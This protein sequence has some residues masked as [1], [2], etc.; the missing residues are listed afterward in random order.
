MLSMKREIAYEL[1]APARRHYN[2][3]RVTVH[4]FK[5][6]WQADLVEMIPFAKMNNKHRYLLTVIDCFSKYAFAVPLKSKNGV[7]VADAMRSILLSDEKPFL[8]PPK[9]LQ[10]DEGKEFFNQHFKK[11]LKEFNIELFRVFTSKKACIIERF[12]RTLKNKMWREFSSNGSYKWLG[13]LKKLLNDYNNSYHRTIKMAPN[14]ITPADEERLL[15]VYN[16]I[17]TSY[18]KK[19]VKK[20]C[21]RKTKEKFR[22]GDIVRISRLKSVFEKGYTPNWSTELFKVIKICPTCPVTYKLEDVK[23]NPVLGGFYSEEMHK[24]K[25]KDTYLVEKVIKR[26]GNRVYVKFLGFPNSEN[27]WI[28]VKDVIR[29]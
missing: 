12:N 24:T 16:K 9:Y 4:G 1:H 5:D 8:K 20:N 23:G 15:Q 19:M 10:T 6:L 7:E 14:D 25:Y 13:L 11:M 21:K 2:R 22:V 28:D 27:Q 17:E 29:K 18:S 26:R 3:R